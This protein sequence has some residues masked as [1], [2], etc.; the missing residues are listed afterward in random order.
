ML[1]TIYLVR[2]L[3]RVVRPDESEFSLGPAR[4]RGYAQLSQLLLTVSCTLASVAD[5]DQEE[6]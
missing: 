5:R 2:V 4:Q 1:A 3:V 6:S